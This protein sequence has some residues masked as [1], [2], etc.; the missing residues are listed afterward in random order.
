[1]QV[2]RDGEAVHAIDTEDNGLIRCPNKREPMLVW[3]DPEAGPP[4]CPACGDR[5]ASWV[6]LPMGE[7]SR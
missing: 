6:M 3:M 5:V 7:G 4:Y 1:M 2:M